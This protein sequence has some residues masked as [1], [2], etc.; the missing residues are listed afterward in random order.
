MNRAV[1][2][3]MAACGI[4]G[5]G[6]ALL[7][8]ALLLWTYTGSRI[9]KIPLDLDATL[10][11]EGSGTTVD[12]ASLY[13]PKLVVDKNV[14]VVSQ[15]QI[16]VESPA[17]A[18]VVTFQV[19]SSVRRSDKQK[20]SGLLLALVDT[21]TLNRK[22]AS[23]VSDDTHP[24]GAVQKPRGFKDE[25]PADQHRAAA[26][27]A[28]LPLPVPHREALVPVLRP[29]RAEGVRGQLQ[30]RRRRQRPDRLQV[31]PRCRLRRGRQAGRADQVPVAVR[32]RRGQQGHQHR[33]HVGP[34]GR[35]G[36]EDHHDP[37]LRRAADVLGRPGV[38]HDRQ[39]TRARQPLLRAGRV[40]ARSD[41]GRLQDHL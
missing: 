29:D 36:R 34:A 31:H 25:S 27:G 16:D 3:R 39:G 18:D 41:A 6:A 40:E 28:V 13:S 30:R 23:A 19:G 32:R 11:G 10:I 14:P 2:L 15:Q 38:G 7:I 4:M 21:V 17:N 26:R 24:G 12:P 37:L 35:S 33:V 9:T 1:M 22:T 20:D 5:L 8:A